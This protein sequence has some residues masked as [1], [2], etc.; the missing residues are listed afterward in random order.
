MNFF[1]D[2]YEDVLDTYGTYFRTVMPKK[3][4]IKHKKVWVRIAVVKKHDK[5]VSNP[6]LWRFFIDRQDPDVQVLNWSMEGMAI[7]GI[8]VVPMATPTPDPDSK[9]ITGLK[10]AIDL[11]GDVTI[12]ENNI[13]HIKLKKPRHKDA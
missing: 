5:S 3:S 6:S 2:I 12:D 7:T 13:A 11:Y 9:G 10:A 8:N 1:R 4:M